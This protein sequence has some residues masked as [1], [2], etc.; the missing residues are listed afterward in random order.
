M[1][2]SSFGLLLF[3]PATQAAS[4]NIPRTDGWREWK[5]G[6][7]MERK[8]KNGFFKLI[9]GRAAASLATFLWLRIP[10]LC[11]IVLIR[12]FLTGCCDL[13]SQSRASTEAD[14]SYALTI[15]LQRLGTVERC[16]GLAKHDRLIPN[17]FDLLNCDHVIYVFSMQ[18]K[19]TVH[20]LFLE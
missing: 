12:I 9:K 3:Y 16:L 14:H 20:F 8:K 19:R 10:R 1:Q 18:P 6:I 11:S 4:H 15:P 13:H 17:L 7:V 2:R 5:W